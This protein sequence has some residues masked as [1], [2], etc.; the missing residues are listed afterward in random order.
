MYRFVRYRKPPIIIREYES[1]SESES[2]SDSE[3]EPEKKT[4]IQQMSNVK[5]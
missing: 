5:I 3:P 2:E 4:L 1:E